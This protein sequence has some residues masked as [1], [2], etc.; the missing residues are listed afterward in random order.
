MPARAHAGGLTLFVNRYCADAGVRYLQAGVELDLYAHH[1]FHMILWYLEHVLSWLAHTLTEAYD[2]YKATGMD[3]CIL[4]INDLAS[5][6]RMTT[7]P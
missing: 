1:E 7:H 5:R 6:S 2:L 3:I 4:P